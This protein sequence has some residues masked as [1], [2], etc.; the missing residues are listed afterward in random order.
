MLRKN[1]MN[2]ALGTHA[3]REELHAT[4]EKLHER[5]LRKKEIEVKQE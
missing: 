2:E 4:R 3:I 1:S 5:S